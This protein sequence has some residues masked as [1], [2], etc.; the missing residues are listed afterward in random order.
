MPVHNARRGASQIAVRV[1]SVELAGFDWGGD[2]APVGGPSIVTS[3]ERILAVQSDG[4]D[5]AF[6]PLTGRRICTMLLSGSL[7]SN[8]MLP[9][10]GNR[11]SPS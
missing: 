7:L 8:S 5:G 6:A 9:S 1:D 10:V 11:H 4:T 2:D 3:K